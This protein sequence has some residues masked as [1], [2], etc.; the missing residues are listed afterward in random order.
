MLS[1][2]DAGAGLRVF[3]G[4]KQRLCLYL[5]YFCAL[6]KRGTFRGAGVE[7]K[8]KRT[9]QGFCHC[10][11][12]AHSAGCFAPARS[13]R[14]PR[15]KVAQQAYQAARDV[16]AEIVQTQVAVFDVL[17][18]ILV[19]NSNGVWAED[20]RARARL[21]VST[22]AS[23]NG[24]I[25]TGFEG[26]GAGRGFEFFSA[27]D[28]DGTAQQAA[29]TALTMLHALYAPAGKMTVA[30]GGGFGGVIFHEACGHS[31]KLQRGQRQQRI[32]R[33]AG[34]K[35]RLKVTVVDDGT[36]QSA[37]GSIGYDDEG[38][39]SQR[40]VLIENGILKGYLI[41][42]MGSRRMGM[43]STGS[44]RRQTIALPHQPHDQHL[45]RRRQRQKRDRL[46]GQRP[47]C[48]KWAAAA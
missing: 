14:R 48:Q 9:L 19:A 43:P 40:N 47:V 15:V 3:S 36:L 5:R 32:C 42:H 27:L 2:L 8:R 31:L 33:P 39:P 7:G 44:G 26:P 34:R 28:I 30:V 23:A 22:V 24:E 17:S 10:A 16:S 1:G 35:D 11:P 13:G 29:Q 45:Y 20:E 6:M 38:H 21:A 18:R 12:A 46:H 37:W 25:Q 4:N 41:D